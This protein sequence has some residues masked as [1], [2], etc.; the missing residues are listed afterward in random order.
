MIDLTASQVIVYASVLSSL[1]AFLVTCLR[2]ARALRDMVAEE[3][4]RAA[5]SSIYRAIHLRA[6]R[7]PAMLDPGAQSPPADGHDALKD[8]RATWLEPNEEFILETDRILNE[9]EW[10][11]MYTAGRIKG[12][13]GEI[14][15]REQSA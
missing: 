2:R 15:R 3:R 9:I 11:R 6:G 8:F 14:A 4:R 5:E 7:E 12:S 13:P 1:A 10:D